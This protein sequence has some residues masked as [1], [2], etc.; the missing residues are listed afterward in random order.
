MKSEV[1]DQTIHNPPGSAKQHGKYY[2]SELGNN[3]RI[4]TRPRKNLR[5]LTAF[6]DNQLTSIL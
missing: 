4:L 2:L 3:N 5:L 6:Y 1:Y